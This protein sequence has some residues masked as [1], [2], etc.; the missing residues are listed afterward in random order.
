MRCGQWVWATCSVKELVSSRGPLKHEN[1]HCQSTHPDSHTVHC[2]HTHCLHFPLALCALLHWL[3]CS[4]IQPSENSCAMVTAAEMC[5]PPETDNIERNNS[6]NNTGNIKSVLAGVCSLPAKSLC[7]KLVCFSWK[8]LKTA[9]SDVVW[10]QQGSTASD[11]F[12]TSLHTMHPSLF[13]VNL[14]G[15]KTVG[16]MVLWYETRPIPSW[17]QHACRE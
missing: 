17:Q 8:I 7:P 9:E 15:S 3:T 13:T 16:L 10:Q 6:L 5:F 4:L 11:N 12:A 14:I 1:T 2:I